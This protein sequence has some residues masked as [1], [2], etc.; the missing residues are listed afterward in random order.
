MRILFWSELFWPY[1]GGIELSGMGLL[2]A[3]RKRGYEFIVVTGHD[4]LD[5]P[6]EGGYE[7]IPLFRFPFRRVLANRQ[8]DQLMEV[9]KRLASIKRT[10][11][12]DLIHINSTASSILF[13]LYTAEVS[14][15]PVLVTLRSGL[16]N[17]SLEQET[18]IGRVLRQS[19]WI[20][21][22]SASLLGDVHQRVPDVV[23]RSSVVP[24][25]LPAQKLLPLPL[26]IDRPNILCLGR[27]INDK[28]FDLAITA[29]ASIVDR[30]PEARMIIAGD[31][32]MRSALERQ[33]ADWKLGDLVT[34]TGLVAPE[35]VPGLLN[36]A[37]VVL[38]PS[39][40]E[41]LPRVALE[42]ALMARPVVAARI[43]GLAEII[44]HGETGCLVEPEDSDALAMAS[45]F[46]L[47]HPDLAARMGEAARKRVQETFSWERCVDTY[48]DLYRRI[49]NAG[50]S[51]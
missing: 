39:R 44:Q 11:A 41:G 19:S 46:L 1:V 4:Y 15:A 21:S 14:P 2:A 38:M 13:Y 12:P 34:F 35:D 24:D 30:Y 10:F 47:E 49:G 5:L 26:P 6:D 20:T 29:F 36:Q 32:P 37:T 42:A 28:G 22:V 25:G 43:G 23:S 48:D 7:G 8:L 3:L 45:L 40:R 18:I 50:L 31:G 16:G 9:R 27:L 51:R 17:A 33:A